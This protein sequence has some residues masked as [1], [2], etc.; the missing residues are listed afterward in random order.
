MTPKQ[1]FAEQ[2]A[3]PGLI[4]ILVGMDTGDKLEVRHKITEGVRITYLIDDKR[5]AVTVVAIRQVNLDT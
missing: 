1:I 5:K 3:E 4:E 2:A